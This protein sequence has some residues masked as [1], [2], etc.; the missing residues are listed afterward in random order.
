MGDEKWKRSNWETFSELLESQLK[1][2][3]SVVRNL[4]LLDAQNNFR[5]KKLTNSLHE[6][7]VTYRARLLIRLK[8]WRQCIPGLR[9]RAPDLET[10]SRSRA[11][12]PAP[13]VIPLFRLWRGGT[14]R[15]KPFI[16]STVSHNI[17]GGILNSAGVKEGEID[18]KKE[19]PKANLADLRDEFI[20]AGAFGLELTSDPSLHLRFDETDFKR[21]T[22]LILDTR[23]LA[24]VALLD[25]TGLMRLPALETLIS[26]K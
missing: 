10:P 12:Q 16:C 5:G 13:E 6:M 23:T 9:G 25:L 24:L 18:L 8:S 26:N 19:T 22:L 15:Q 11:P 21:P 2:I 20:L 14:K 7:P 4:L 1:R 3:Y 17:R